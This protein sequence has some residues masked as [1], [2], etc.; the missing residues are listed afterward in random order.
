MKLIVMALPIFCLVPLFLM[1]GQTDEP[2]KS[3]SRRENVLVEMLKHAS[4]DTE[5]AADYS[6]QAFQ[7]VA[8]GDS[9]E[10]VEAKIGKPLTTRADKPY[11]AWLY[12]PEQHP[13]FA[14][15]TSFIRERLP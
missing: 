8:I 10:S 5:Y 4:Q 12:A 2:T 13:S 14:A 9:I 3:S 6:E 15:L 1:G 7:K 11:T